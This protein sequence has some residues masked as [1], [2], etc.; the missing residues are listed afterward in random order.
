MDPYW[1]A[2]EPGYNTLVV[3]PF[4]AGTLTGSEALTRHRHEVVSTLGK[5]KHK[6]RLATSTFAARERIMPAAIKQVLSLRGAH[7]SDFL[8]RNEPVTDPIA[9]WTA[10]GYVY[11]QLFV[12]KLLGV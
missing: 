7:G 9:F 8:H 6:P 11:Q 3:Q 12:Q 10:I 1:L 2:T 5:L 4:L